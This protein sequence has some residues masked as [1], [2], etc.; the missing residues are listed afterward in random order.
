[1]ANVARHAAAGAVQ[2]SLKK[3]AGVV[4][5]SVRDNGRGIA[6]EEIDSPATMGLLGMRERA[7][8]VG[9][10]V[11][12][13][14]GLRGGTTVMAILPLPSEPSVSAAAEGPALR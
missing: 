6:P 13:T 1:L 10:D 14:R 8:S 5:L 11:R 3:S 12:I 4:F 2:L 9:G 7:L